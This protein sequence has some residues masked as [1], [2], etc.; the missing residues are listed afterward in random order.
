MDGHIDPNVSLTF[1]ELQQR[2]ERVTDEVAVPRDLILGVDDEPAIR[3][4]SLHGILNWLK[5]GAQSDLEWTINSE[6]LELCLSEMRAASWP[7]PAVPQAV[8]HLESMLTAMWSR[9]RRHAF[10]LGVT[11]LAEL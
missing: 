5:S 3:R 10:D 11:A 6:K 1:E 8:H 9:N 4:E 7:L 2:N